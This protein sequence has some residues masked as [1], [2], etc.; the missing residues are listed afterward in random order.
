MHRFYGRH[1]NLRLNI[2]APSAPDKQWVADLTYIKVAG[3]WMYLAVVMDLYSRRI[4]G[5]SLGSHKTAE[6][7][8]R[9]LR[10]TLSVRSPDA[11]LIFH[12]DR[13]VEYGAE[14]IQ[15]E[16]QRHDSRHSMN[17]PGKCTDNAHMESF[18]HT[19]K[20]EKL[21]GTAFTSV[22]ELRRSINQY[23]DGFYNTTRLHSSLDY[24]SPMEH[25]RMAA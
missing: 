3:N 17:R 20:S 23:I 6:L 12:T 15:N 25:E 21:H 5:W 18:F 7:T 8:L 16:L 11:G 4:V 22:R 13:G 14:L 10:Q 19:L 9:A 2:P 24:V 1:A